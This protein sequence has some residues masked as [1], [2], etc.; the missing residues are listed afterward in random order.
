MTAS[1]EPERVD[2]G[3]QVLRG[4]DAREVADDDRFGFGQGLFGVRRSR[5]VARMQDDL[6][7]LIGENLTDHEAE[8]VGRTGNE[9]ARHAVL[10]TLRLHM[11]ISRFALARASVKEHTP[12][13]GS[14]MVALHSGLLSHWRSLGSGEVA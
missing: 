1:K 4:G 14:C 8:A 5:V 9:D 11:H 6:M 12:D 2:L 7:P 10:P 13:G 3:R